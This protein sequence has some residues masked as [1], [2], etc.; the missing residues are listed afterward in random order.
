MN[1]ENSSTYY[2]QTMPGFEEIAWLEIRDRCPDA[3]FGEYLYAKD[4]NGILVFDYGGKINQLLQMRTTEDIFLQALN[5]KSMSR[6]KR[7]LAQITQLVSKGESFGR[8]VNNLMRWRQFSGPPTFRVVSR[9]Y[10]KHQ[11][12]RKDLESAVFYG[13]QS[14]YSRWRPV[15]DGG[16]VEIWANLLGS[17][18]LIGLRLSD[19]SMRHRYNKKVELPASLRPS[20]AAA[21]V[22]LT[23]PEADDVF[24]DPMC[25]SGTILLERMH[26]GP[27]KQILGGDIDNTRVDAARQN[28]P[29]HRKGRKENLIFVR[30]WDAQNLPL[31]DGSVNK[32]TTNLPFGKQI[33]S[34]QDLE[35]LYHG[36]FSELSRVVIPDGRIVLLSSEYDLIKQLMRR[37]PALE[38]LG[39]YSVATLGTWARIYLI[40]RKP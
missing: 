30:Q 27:Y 18:L 14:R 34:T 19:R 25:G 4:Q 10:G 29:K 33:G 22:Y 5:Q 20:M 13:V 11:Y 9:K 21:M 40:T 12:R 2:A 8:A 7:D 1:K 38:I 28:L 32:V 31:E 37:Q 17:H 26:A 15:A 36:L 3:S 23:I 39:G 16:Q 24:L 35:P 6:G